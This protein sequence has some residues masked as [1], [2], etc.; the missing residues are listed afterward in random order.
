MIHPKVFEITET[1]ESD[2]FATFLDIDL[3]F[4][5]NGQ[6]STILYDKGDDFNFRII[7]FQQHDSYILDIL[8][9][10]V[11]ISQRIR[12]VQTCT[13]YFGLNMSLYFEFCSV[14]SRIIKE[15]SSLSKRFSE[16]INDVIIEQN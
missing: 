15:S 5:N 9:H 8:S 2:S 10:G 13:M 16:D 6:V 3:I 12:Y 7:Y 14:M 1:T 11:Y 4:Y